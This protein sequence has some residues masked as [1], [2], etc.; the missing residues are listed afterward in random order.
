MSERTVRVEGDQEG[1]GPDVGEEDVEAIKAERDYWRALFNGLVET[2]PE[3]VLVVDDG[4][5]LTH[6]NDAVADITAVDPA[7]AVG[8]PANEVAGVDET[9]AERAARLDEPVSA[10]EIRSGTSRNGAEW[11]TQDVAVPLRDHEGNTV[12]GFEIALRVTDLVRMREELETAQATIREEI[13]KSVVDLGD[14]SEEVADRVQEISSV[15]ADQSESMAT[16]SQEIADLSATIE[17]IA[18]TADEVATT[19]RQATDVAEDGRDAAADAVDAMDETADS[20]GEVAAEVDDLNERVAEI[21]EI[22]GVINDIAD[23]TN[24]LAL[25]ASI[26]AAKAGDAGDGFAVVA[27]EVKSLA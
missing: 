8:N 20:A 19:S 4:G 1:L 18:S 16:V 23:Q 5:R 21:D 25:N 6:W 26:E 14:S 22:V 27:D 13:Q 9:I 24:I 3:P 17:E 10:D 2:L 12:G 11:H 15:A 7:E